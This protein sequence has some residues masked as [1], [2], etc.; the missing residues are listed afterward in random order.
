MTDTEP[1]EKPTVPLRK[2]EFSE[3][4]HPDDASF[5]KFVKALDRAY[6]RPLL[7]MWRSF[8]MGVATALGATVGAAIIL[9]ILFYVLKTFD[10]APYATKIQEIIIPESIR[11]QLDGSSTPTPQV[12]YSPS[13][14]TAQ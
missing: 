14:T 6:H 4:R 9:V 12:Y 8:L 2:D 7:M 10:F 1:V 13:T 3:Y 5:D 11:K